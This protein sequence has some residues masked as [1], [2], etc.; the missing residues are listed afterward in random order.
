MGKKF[1][2]RVGTRTTPR[3]QSAI[4]AAKEGRMEQRHLDYVMAKY[5]AAL[6]YPLDTLLGRNRIGKIPLDEFIEDCVKDAFVR[7]NEYDPQYKFRTFLVNKIVW[8]A[9]N[10]IRL[11]NKRENEAIN[12]YLD[13]DDA[14]E[15]FTGILSKAMA[16]IFI[17]EG[18]KQLKEQEPL[19]YEVLYLHYFKKLPYKAI[20]EELKDS[21]TMRVSSVDY[22]EKL[23]Q[24]AVKQLKHLYRELVRNRKFVDNDLPFTAGLKR[25]LYEV[26]TEKRNHR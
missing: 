1:F 14:K 5:R 18:L 8:P 12:H 23:Y 20:Y 13:R 11:E 15:D 25:K 19:K 17:D 16:K 24:R 26:T 21:V 10:K 2:I 4:K 9:L 22:A 3:K 7:I 6:Y